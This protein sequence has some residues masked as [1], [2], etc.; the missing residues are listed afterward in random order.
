MFDGSRAFGGKEGS[1][2]S[3][4]WSWGVSFGVGE[5]K[6]CREVVGLPDATKLER[7]FDPNVCSA[8]A[9]LLCATIESPAF[10]PGFILHS[11]HSVPTEE[12][13][14]NLSH[15]YSADRAAL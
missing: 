12:P 14:K 11:E 8:S 10:L 3:R 6:R 2:Q 9:S 15:A 4:L 1:E 13:R 7:K 5:S